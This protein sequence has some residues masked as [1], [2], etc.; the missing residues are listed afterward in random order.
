MP[1]KPT[2]NTVLEQLIFFAFSA[3]MVPSF[4]ACSLIYRE[5]ILIDNLTG[6]GLVNPA[7]SLLYTLK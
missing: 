4:S 3:E 2:D 1:Y 6:T 7:K 5:I